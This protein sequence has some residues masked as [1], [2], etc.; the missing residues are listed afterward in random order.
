MD[1]NSQE[2]NERPFCGKCGLEIN[3]HVG[4]C[5]GCVLKVAVESLSASDHPALGPIAV[6]G[7]SPIVESLNQQF[8]DYEFVELIGRGG[9]GWT[10]LATQK[11]LARNVAIKLLSRSDARRNE[12][13]RFQKEAGNLAKLNHSNIV[14]VHDFG[15]TDQFLYIVMEYVPNLT[16][17]R[18][19][20][21]GKLDAEQVCAIGSQICRALEIAHETGLIHRD[22]K[23]ENILVVKS[24]PEFE[25]RVA[26]FGISQ[27]TA[28]NSVLDSVNGLTATG[29]IIGTP[30]YMAP[31]QQIPG[32]TIDR[33]ADIFSTAVVLYELLTGQLPQG[34]FPPPS[35]FGRCDAALDAILI[36]A[37]S[38]DPN[39]RFE[40]AGEFADQ[41]E[42][43][44]APGAEKPGSKWAVPVLVLA[45]LI[46]LLVLPF[47]LP[48][49]FDKTSGEQENEI[50]ALSEPDAKQKTIEQQDSPKQ[51]NETTPQ[52]NET[53]PQ[54]EPPLIPKI[55]QNLL[56]EIS[57]ND[58]RKTRSALTSLKNAPPV[59]EINSITE[60]V[61]QLTLDTNSFVSLQ[62]I[63][64]LIALN[65]EKG[66][67]A[68]AK[69]MEGGVHSKSRAIMVVDKLA[70]SRFIPI[71]AK[72]LN[73]NR[74][75]RVVRALVLLGPESESTL[76]SYVQQQ[77]SW[78]YMIPAIEAIG[79]IGSEDS[80]ELLE[81][82]ESSTE[83]FVGPAATK[84]IAAIKARIDQKPAEQ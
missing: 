83:S 60:R 16:L 20:S 33:R 26:D 24:E 15:A 68:L 58:S 7:R 55:Y 74:S 59:P 5:A 10:F 23:P 72:E 61:A 52:K 29:L 49:L 35:Q 39:N 44:W 50:A 6:K 11:S 30:F 22:I 12:L 78:L 77:Q 32:K 79:E 37:L 14:T 70:D 9:S 48:R 8:S 40:T 21:R 27:L 46:L 4:V 80:F 13:E 73:K 31:E 45:G 57:S 36:R 64:T 53:A 62:A 28:S 34:S 3:H 18:W 69:A 67:E 54:D 51:K 17:R 47:G 76:Q 1:T 2:L 75:R 38:N 65:F 81:S 82:L 71:L 43:Q 66:Y 56:E 42:S 63:E 25:I 19:A 84:A 41:L